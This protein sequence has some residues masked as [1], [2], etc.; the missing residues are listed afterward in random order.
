MMP[1]AILSILGAGNNGGINIETF[2]PCSDFE[3]VGQFD[4]E[5]TEDNSGSNCYNNPSDPFPGIGVLRRNEAVCGVEHDGFPSYR[6]CVCLECGGSTMLPSRLNCFVQLELVS[7][8]DR[9]LTSVQAEGPVQREVGMI[10]ALRRVFLDGFRKCVQETPSCRFFELDMRGILELAID[11]KDVAGIDDTEL[12]STHNA[13]PGFVIVF[14]LDVLQIFAHGFG[15][16]EVVFERGYGTVDQFGEVNATRVAA[17]DH[18]R[19]AECHVRADAD[20]DAR[21]QP[22]SKGF[23]VAVADADA[24]MPLRRR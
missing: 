23:V 19:T 22:N 6:I 1:R 15:R 17:F 11:R 9:R 20:D 21:R 18:G 13:T 24:A 10:H 3:V 8:K 16:Q 2:P 14:E 7:G 12:G 5:L 4:T